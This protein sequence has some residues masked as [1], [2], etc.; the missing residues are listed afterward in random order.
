MPFIN[1]N[2]HTNLYYKEWGAASLWS[3]SPDGA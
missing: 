1:S 2:D 3:S